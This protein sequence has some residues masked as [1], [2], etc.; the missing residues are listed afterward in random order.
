MQREPRRLLILALA[1]LAFAGC[2]GDDEE[3]VETT[4]TVPATVPVDPPVE[5]MPATT[6]E[7]DEYKEFCEENPG[8]C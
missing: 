3:S 4:P 5:T 2:G 1:A 8:A 7:E 6:P